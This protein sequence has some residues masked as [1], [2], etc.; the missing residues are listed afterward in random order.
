MADTA[1]TDTL[2][3]PHAARADLISNRLLGALRWRELERLTPHL[4]KVEL[5]R[6]ALLF[7][8]GEDV[9]ITHLPCH[10][11]MVSLL[12]VAE[13]GQE[14]EVANVGRE[15]AVGGIVSAGFKP[16]YGRAIVRAPG[17]AFCI[18]TARL[19]EAKSQSPALADLF[20][21][22]ADVL[23]AQMMQSTACNALHGVEQRYCRWLLS[24]H[25]RCGSEP[26]RLTQETLAQMMGV[27]R[28]TV[29]AVA[30]T[31]Q[32]HGVIAAGRGRIEI[33]NRAALERRAC[34]CHD[35]VERHFQRVLPEVDTDA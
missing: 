21:R 22:Y 20:A 11:T 4:R 9:T 17:F 34:E 19:E 16:A 35:A 7:D 5:Q 13:D 12:V 31:L 23:L 25:D 6:D 8:C 33:L 14:V 28:T 10:A 29:T 24:A 3:E 32:D 2:R 30:K 1:Q 18:P 15:G 26:I 27:Q